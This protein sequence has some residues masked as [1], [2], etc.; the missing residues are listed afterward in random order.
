MRWRAA[1][2]GEEDGQMCKEG[3]SA[4]WAPG[5]S[6]RSAGQPRENRV[7]A[8][9]PVEAGLWEVSCPPVA[10]SAPQ[11]FPAAGGPAAEGTGKEIAFLRLLS[12]IPTGLC[13]NSDFPSTPKPP[14]GG[15]L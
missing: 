5:M 1:A 12:H 9:G 14:E 3:L 2:L 11:P 13:S 15:L 10:A 6:S 4:P 8:K 7:R